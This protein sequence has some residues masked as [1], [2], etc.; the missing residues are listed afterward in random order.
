M[1]HYPSTE[2]LADGTYVNKLAADL[3]PFLLL[4]LSHF[5]VK[6]NFHDWFTENKQTSQ[7]PYSRMLT[8]ADR[9]FFRADTVL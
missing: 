3:L 1:A 2:L 8:G 4:G 5:N 7:V 6:T 9:S